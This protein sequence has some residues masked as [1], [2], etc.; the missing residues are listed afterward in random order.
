[1][2]SM[3]SV[4]TA[5]GVGTAV[6]GSSFTGSGEGVF[7]AVVLDLAGVVFLTVVSDLE[8]FFPWVEVVAA[9]SGAPVPA[10]M[11]MTSRSRSK[12]CMRFG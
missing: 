10:A 9:S 3:L 7:L 11:S 5:A 8:D 12:V 2:S 4:E 1:M 6:G